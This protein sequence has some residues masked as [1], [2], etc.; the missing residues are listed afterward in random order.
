VA[1]VKTGGV[2]LLVLNGKEEQETKE[3]CDGIDIA[4]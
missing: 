2:L 4:A 1:I 3:E